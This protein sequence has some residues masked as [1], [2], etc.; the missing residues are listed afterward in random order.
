MPS[1]CTISV[2]IPQD[3]ESF[4]GT[5]YKSGSGLS[6]QHYY[7]DYKNQDLS[8]T[9]S[10]LRLQKKR[11]A[12]LLKRIEGIAA[13]Q[14]NWNGYGATSFS[15]EV[16]QK[17]RSFVEDVVYYKTKVFPTGRDSIQFEFDSIPGKY[18]EIEVFS[19]HYAMLFEKGAAQ[20]E[21]DSV[22]RNCVLQKI[23]E[24]YA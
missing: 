12:Q 21:Y 22:T 19:D 6:Q 11:K 15:P 14:A 7:C 20:E 17:A 13:L 18:L 1:D 5:G 3:R 4:I 23:A 2:P 8:D 24:Y 10:L 9:S 16:L